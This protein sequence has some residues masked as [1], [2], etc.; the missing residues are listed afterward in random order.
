MEKL[1]SLVLMH[2]NRQLRDIVQ[3]PRLLERGL[4]VLSKCHLRPLPSSS[5]YVSLCLLHL[6]VKQPHLFHT[7]EPH[8]KKTALHKTYIDIPE[9][10]RRLLYHFLRLS[11]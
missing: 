3:Y 6:H 4:C 8:Y 1:N 10:S 5:E 11:V 7:Q 2:S 9:F